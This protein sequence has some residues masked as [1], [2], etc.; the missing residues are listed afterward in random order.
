MHPL[1]I[2]L[3]WGCMPHSPHLQAQGEPQRVFTGKSARHEQRSTSEEGFLARQC[4]LWH[5]RSKEVLQAL[6]ERLELL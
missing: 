3:C 5:Q 4:H 1:Y 2:L 6:V